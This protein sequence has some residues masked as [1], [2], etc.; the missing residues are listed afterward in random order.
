[1]ISLSPLVCSLKEQN[2]K[3]DA[4]AAIKV[5]ITQFAILKARKPST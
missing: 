4:K 3:V 5:Q 2:Q 1:M